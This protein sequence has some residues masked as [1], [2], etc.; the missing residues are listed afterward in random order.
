[1]LKSATSKVMWLGRATVFMVGLAVILALVFGAASTAL[2]ATGGNFILGKANSAGA[3]SK[4]TTN[5]ANPALQLVNNSTGAAATALNL[6]VA[7]GKPPLTVNAAAGKATNLNADKLDARNSEDLGSHAKMTTSLEDFNL[8][9]DINAFGGQVQSIATLPLSVPGNTPQVVRLD[10]YLEL[11]DTMGPGAG[12]P[13]EFRMEIVD[14]TTNTTV[15][16]ADQTFFGTDTELSHWT[17]SQPVLMTQ[18]AP[19]SHTYQLRGKVLDRDEIVN[20]TSFDLS[21]VRLIAQTIP[22]S[23]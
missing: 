19:G 15:G 8:P 4:L 3:V 18:A 2:S 13:C 7:S 17:M 20:N 1:M 14:T 21:N 11:S 5:I 23:S 16:T 9:T 10:G 12:C 22:F 6:S